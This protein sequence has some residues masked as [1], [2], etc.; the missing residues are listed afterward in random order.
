MERIKVLKVLLI[1]ISLFISSSLWA[2]EDQNEKGQPQINILSSPLSSHPLLPLVGTGT[3]VYIAYRD[4][5][6][7]MAKKP[8]ELVDPWTHITTGHARPLTGH[9]GFL[10]VYPDGFSYMIDTISATGVRITDLN[11]FN[12]G[13]AQNL[14]FFDAKLNQEQTTELVG[15]LGKRVGSNEEGKPKYPWVLSKKGPHEYN[16]VGLVE[17]G[18][19]YISEKF[20]DPNLNLTTNEIEKG[21]FFPYEQLKESSKKLKKVDITDIWPNEKKNVPPRPKSPANDHPDDYVGVLSPS[22]ITQSDAPL[23]NVAVLYNGFP[24]E[25]SSIISDSCW[26]APGFKLEDAMDYPAI[27]IPSGGLFGLDSSEILKGKIAR[28]VEQGGI[29]VC[30][31][32]QHG[33][34]F[35]ALPRQ[36]E[37]SA[38]GWQEDQSCW[39]NAAYI[40]TDHPIFASQVAATLNV[41][42]DGY[43]SQWPNDATVLLRRTKN[44]MP[45]MISY[46]YGSGTVIAATL[47]S[48]FGIS[49]G[50]TSNDELL[51]IN[52]LVSFVENK[53]KPIREYKPKD[54]VE[55]GITLTYEEIYRMFQ[56]N[57]IDATAVTFTLRGADKAVITSYDCSLQTP[58][59]SRQTQTATFTTICP[60]KYGIY[61]INYTLKNDNG[62]VVKPETKAQCFFV[63]KHLTNSTKLDG[64]KIWATAEEQV[65]A[66]SNVGYTIFV[67][68]DTDKDFTG[69]IGVGVHEENAS[70]GRWWAYV[71]T[72][73]DVSISAHSQGNFTFTQQMRISA[74]TYFGLF[75]N[76]SRCNTYLLQ[77]AIASC[78]KGVWVVKPSVE[79]MEISNSEF[80]PGSLLSGTITMTNQFSIGYTINLKITIKELG[81]SSDFPIELQQNSTIAFPISI[82]IPATA[83]AG[84]CI[85]NIG[86]DNATLALKT[87]RILDTRAWIDRYNYTSGDDVK[88]HM[89]NLSP[90]E[91]SLNYE[92]SLLDKDNI[93]V[94]NNKGVISLS[95]NEE[96]S[97]SLPLE[98]VVSGEYVLKTTINGYDLMNQR[99]KVSGVS[100][101]IITITDKGFYLPDQTI[102]T[103][104]RVTNTG[105][106]I[107]DGKLKIKAYRRN[108]IQLKNQL[109][110]F[111]INPKGV[112]DWASIGD[113]GNLL[114]ACNLAIKFSR[115]SCGEQIKWLDELKVIGRRQIDNYYEVTSFYPIDNGS[116]T[117]G[118]GLKIISHYLLYDDKP[119]VDGWYRVEIEGDIMLSDVTI[120]PFME[121]LSA[122]IG[123]TGMESSSNSKWEMA[124]DYNRNNYFSRFW[125]E[126]MAWTWPVPND[127]FSIGSD[128]RIGMSFVVHDNPEG[129]PQFAPRLLWG[130]VLPNTL[131]PGNAEEIRQEIMRGGSFD[132][133]ATSSA[134]A[135]GVK[136]L[137]GDIN[138]LSPFVD[139]NFR[140]E[141][142]VEDGT[143]NDDETNTVEPSASDIIIYEKEM[144]VNMNSGNIMDYMIDMPSV[145]SVRKYYITSELI[146][147]SGQSICKDTTGFEVVDEDITVSLHL[148]K[149]SYRQGEII[150]ITVSVRNNS[151]AQERQL[152]LR[153]AK[154]TET[155]F[156]S[157]A[158]DLESET[159]ATFTT[160]IIAERSCLL[161]AIVGSFTD[162]C[163]V[164][165]G[166]PAMDVRITAPEVVDDGTYSLT[167]RIENKGKIAVPVQGKWTIGNADG[168]IENINLEPG[169]VRLFT[170]EFKI[171]QNEVIQV[172]LANVGT[173]TLPVRYYKGAVVEV[174]GI[175]NEPIF[176]PMQAGTVSIQVRNKG[177]MVGKVTLRLKV[178]DMVDEESHIWLMPDEVGTF[179]YSVRFDDDLEAGT[180]TGRMEV[181]IDDKVIGA[182]DVRFVLDGI[183]INVDTRLDKWYYNKGDIARLMLLVE[184]K[185]AGTIALQAKVQ[186]QIKAFEIKE[187]GSA[188]LVFDIPVDNGLENLQYG[189]YT[190]SNRAVYLNACYLRQGEG[191]VIV[192]EKDVYLAGATM[193][194][195]VITHETG[196]LSLWWM[197]DAKSY[198][199]NGTSTMLLKVPEEILS[200]SYPFRWEFNDK[201]GSLSIDVKGLEIQVVDAEFFEGLVTE[202]SNTWDMRLRA[203]VNQGC[204]GLV[205]IWLYSPIEGKYTLLIEKSVGFDCGINSINISG[206]MTTSYAGSYKIIYEIYVDDMLCASGMEWVDIMQKVVVTSR[207][208]WGWN[209][210]SIPFMLDNA[211][212][213]GVFG[214]N[215]SGDIWMY[216]WDGQAYEYKPVI[217]EIKPGKGY[218]FGV[219]GTTTIDIIGNMVDESKEYSLTLNKGWNMI[220]CPFR[221]TPDWSKAMIEYQ[222]GRKSLMDAENQGWIKNRLFGFNPLEWEYYLAE[223]VKPM[224]GYWFPAMVDCKLIISPIP[225]GIAGA[226]K[227]LEAPVLADWQVNINASCG[228][229]HDRVVIGASKEAREGMDAVD[230]IEP[231]FITGLSI[232]CY[233]P[234]EL[235]G[236]FQRD[237]KGL[238][239]KLVWDVRVKSNLLDEVVIDWND[240]PSGYRFTM[241][242]V[243]TDKQMD[244]STNR[245]YHYQTMLSKSDM[246]PPDLDKI[247]GVHSFKIIATKEGAKAAGIRVYPNPTSSKVTFDGVSPN[248]EIKIFTI[249]G[250]LVRIIQG[251]RIWQLDNETGKQVANGVYLW[252][253]V[254]GERKQTGKIG[255]IK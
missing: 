118:S 21:G 191:M 19:E 27:I 250:E 207:V 201:S 227:Q 45:A 230:E 185:G 30:F 254:D 15:W 2:N 251:S 169:V 8:S 139:L 236:E 158:F 114:K 57:P 152:V 99:I 136:Y 22:L 122:S 196:T 222:G 134:N 60:D 181:L 177:T 186:E 107:I 68:N 74:S 6:G 160:E 95:G 137:L 3:K 218:W 189:I 125:P 70:G 14:W 71:G 84:T 246:A 88:V 195:M 127:V 223:G 198:M 24:D 208:Y 31:A 81:I 197:D 34:D 112:I 38:Y 148:P 91:K 232:S 225:V 180:Y 184:N 46:P 145:Q 12:D 123:N 58:L 151:L 135:I 98:Q 252:L 237:V 77:G 109:V 93:C 65:L 111:K 86:V 116:S 103:T 187:S 182:G 87:F 209:M 155:M 82:P 175:T 192:P 217:D 200:G 178:L 43:F 221:F 23:S 213:Q 220:G 188:T 11:G 102:T 72:I 211:T 80:V 20:K 144:S 162:A 83:T 199:I 119:Y 5:D 203:R 51:L 56:E 7:K 101:S 54:Q 49:H 253:V 174:T 255:V 167:V 96:C 10:I 249:S 16:C 78:E 61:W 140:L 245:D 108:T 36:D 131:S 42:V 106:D 161:R 228:R 242:D 193:S 156:T 138:P 53:A 129:G 59:S 33:D 238:S 244:M 142:R 90:I 212:L 1:V 115:P 121:T 67:R 62:E 154:G 37:V 110:K 44:Q 149:D 224:E 173:Y 79:G 97:I 233:H 247:N 146:S 32:Q 25:A 113:G 52:D 159:T 63:S 229:Y 202:T 18:L 147:K 28:Y 194:L 35:K 204:N 205:K 172:V 168:W 166:E 234:E 239:D 76:G 17:A 92:I 219:L 48:D 73:T 150:P 243:E 226:P 130:I 126:E 55:I 179:S 133:G 164:V 235:F 215:V 85:L 4:T 41:G 120:Y 240:L 29:V 75:P 153:I 190:L 94:K 89:K 47:Y 117:S 171:N 214:D 165:V 39:Q 9:A 64:Y 66:G 231:P 248:A 163:E 183:K 141:A 100:A 40:E 13:Q 104:S 128:T 210:I 241:I 50:L 69:N 157:P 105:M 206:S 170:Q 143:N 176:Y 132:Y 216:Q 124:N 26:L